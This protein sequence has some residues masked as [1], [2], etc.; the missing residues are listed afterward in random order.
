MF[1]IGP[2]INELTKDRLREA[3]NARL[4]RSVSTRSEEP[5]KPPRRGIRGLATRIAALATLR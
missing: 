1:P 2:I 5:R 3:E 4:A